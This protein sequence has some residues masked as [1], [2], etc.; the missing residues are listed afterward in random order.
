MA[1]AFVCSV[2]RLQGWTCAA[3]STASTAEH[4]F[5]ST[6]RVS[7]PSTPHFADHF[8]EYESGAQV[9]FAFSGERFAFCSKRGCCQRETVLNKQASH[10]PSARLGDHVA[11]TAF[12]PESFAFCSKNGRCQC[13][14]VLQKK[15]SHDPSSRLDFV[16]DTA[17][18]QRAS[19]F[20]ARTDVASVRQ[21]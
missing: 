20:A 13:E 7:H 16:G 11:D 9:L 1:I 12:S 2:A 3:A 4:L 14:T 18:C 8:N 19:H 5:V 17:F 15:A 10:D 21:C 6:H